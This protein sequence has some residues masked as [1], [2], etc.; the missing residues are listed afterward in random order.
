M[1]ALPI[2]SSVIE[3]KPSLCDQTRNGRIGSEHYEVWVLETEE[4]TLNSCWR[5]FEIAWTVAEVRSG[6]VQIVGA[7]YEHGKEVERKTVVELRMPKE[8]DPETL[9]VLSFHEVS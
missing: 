2:L 7:K 5:D 3:N 8:V 1:S 4:W 9:P 6:P